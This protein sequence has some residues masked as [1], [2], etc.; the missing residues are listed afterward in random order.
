[1]MLPPPPPGSEWWCYRRSRW[2]VLADH[3]DDDA[4]PEPDGLTLV[5]WVRRTGREGEAGLPATVGS[6]PDRRAASGR[7]QGRA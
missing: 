2:R 5:R 1:M 7:P 3:P 4:A 6:S